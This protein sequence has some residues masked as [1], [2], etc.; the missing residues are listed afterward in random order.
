MAKVYLSSTY[1]D[2]EECRQA[3]FDTLQNLQLQVV[4]M[5]HRA[6]RNRAQGAQRPG[7]GV[8]FLDKP[9]EKGSVPGNGVRTQAHQRSDWLPGHRTLS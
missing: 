4:A 9:V 5:E 6:T 8:V 3:V 1:A 2:L 7:A